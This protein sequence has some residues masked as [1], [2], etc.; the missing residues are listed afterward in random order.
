M[1]SIKPQSPLY[2]LADAEIRTRV[3]QLAPAL[4]ETQSHLTAG[5]RICSSPDRDEAKA[6]CDAAGATLREPSSTNLLYYCEAPDS[7]T[8]DQD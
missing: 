5:K 4:L 2:S 6:C 3:T 1:N 8:W 7:G